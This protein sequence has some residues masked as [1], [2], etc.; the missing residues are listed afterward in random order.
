[1][2]TPREI[3]N[4]L[5]QRASELGFQLS[6]ACAA[7]SPPG[8][9]RFD[10]WLAEGYA[11]E[12]HYLSE[13]RDAYQDPNRVLEGV[14]SLLVLGMAYRTA[15]P[16]RASPGQGRVST[17]AWGEQD[18]HQ[19]MRS[20]LHQLADDLREKA[21]EAKT[22]CTVDT[23]PILERDFAR[24]AGIGWIGKNTLLINKPRGSYYFLGALLT[25]LELVYDQPMEVDHCGTCTAC[26]DAC[27]TDAFPEPFVLD[28]RRCISY[29]TI[30]SRSPVPMSLREGVGDWLFGCDDC[31]DVCPW[32]KKP[33]SSEESAFMPLAGMNPVELAE[34]FTMEDEHFRERFR[35]TPLWRAHREGLLRN[36]AIVLGNCP[37]EEA[38]PALVKG[39]GD[40]HPMVRGA[41]AWALGQLASDAA[42][43]ALE[44]RAV[45]ESDASVLEEITQALATSEASGRA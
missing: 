20:R 7:A 37:T 28:A 30:E 39:L 21:P 17:Y 5:K 42:T 41:S 9:S 22:R 6:G 35:H 11:G 32:N 12:M 14:R 43:V 29:L 2:N 27:P 24:M 10:E 1:M 44:A 18:Y 3:T 26:L 4:W 25:D 36:A 34:L 16:A 45:F 38:L 13:R 31:Q 8:A 15:E 33:V 40:E 23:A 19:V